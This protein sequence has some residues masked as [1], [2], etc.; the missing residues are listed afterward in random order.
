MHLTPI[1]PA[2][3]GIAIRFKM[4]TYR[5]SL[6]SYQRFLIGLNLLQGLGLC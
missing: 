6:T 5:I 1:G 2:C 3:G 4:L